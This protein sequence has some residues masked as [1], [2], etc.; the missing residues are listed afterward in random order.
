MA[1]R[2]KANDQQVDKA[3]E[4]AEEVV[5]APAFESTN[6]VNKKVVMTATGIS[7]TV[8]RN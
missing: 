7:M 6:T 4:A 8:V 2:R 5:S 1:R 3:V